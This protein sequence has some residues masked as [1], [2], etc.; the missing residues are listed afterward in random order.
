MSTIRQHVMRLGFLIITLAA[1][2]PARAQ[3]TGIISGTVVDSSDQVLPG[4]TVTLVDEATGATR[5]LTSNERGEFAFRARRP[6]QLH[7]R[8]RTAGFPEIRAPRTT[9]ST[10]A[11]SLDARQREARHRHD[12]R[13]R[14]GRRAGHGRRDQEQRLLRPA[15]RRARSRRFRP[16]DATSSTCCGCC[17]ASTTRTTSTRWATASARRSRT[18]AVSGAPGIR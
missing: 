18:S 14:L 17:P 1:A 13:G 8:R 6:R 10:P 12:Q 3:D 9:S 4:A 7:G 15:D 2:L 16:R 11:A 5:T